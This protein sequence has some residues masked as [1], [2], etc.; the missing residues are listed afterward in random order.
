VAA[1]VEKLLGAS[2]PLRAVREAL[3]GEDAWIVGGTVRDALLGR[4]LADLD[5]A[6]AG[7]AGRAA[8]RIAPALRGPAFPLSE[9]FGAWRVL[10]RDRRFSCDLSPLQGPTI[11]ADLRRRDFTVN[12]M[13]VPL[14]GGGLL[15]PLGGLR[16]LDAGVLRVLEAGEDAYAA[17]ALR[18]LRLARLATELPLRPDAQTAELTRRAAPRVREASGERVWGELRRIVAAPRVVEGMRLADEL[19]LVEPILPELHALHGVE[20]STF[21]HLDVF[22]HTLEA[23]GHLIELERFPAEVFGEAAPELVAVLDEPLGDG[24]TRGGALRLAALLHDVGKPA[25]RGIRADGKGFS[26]V[27]HDRVG[28]ELAHAACRRLRTS[29][30]LASFAAACAR[31]H[32][33]LGFLVHERPLSRRSVYGYLT[34]CEPV[35]VEVTLL[36]C[37]D[38]LATRGANADRAIAAHLALAGELMTEAL[39]WRRAGPPRPAVRGDELARALGIPPGPELG[40]ILRRL[41]EA[42]FTGEAPEPEAALALARRVREN[43]GA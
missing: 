39:R 2:A 18:P 21:H 41:Q 4:P 13:A 14:A 28:A 37:A 25:T 33:V 20:Q 15:D 22:D 23:L 8:R 10:D 24:L 16:D 36:T 32:L 42:S 12:A 1:A 3:R 26:F 17:D 31:H 30:R 7:D 43:P 27:G 19:G 5:L 34:T 40:R 6:V 38:R 35:A 11:E 9:A 29:E